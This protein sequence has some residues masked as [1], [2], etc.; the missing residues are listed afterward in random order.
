ML[1]FLRTAYPDASVDVAESSAGGVTIDIRFED[2][3]LVV[4]YSPRLGFGASLV[5]SDDQAFTGHD[6]AF[7]DS[8]EVIGYLTRA[9][10]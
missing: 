3:F 8:A 5:Q 4:Q 2:L 9:M 1:Q 7:A 6:H 10:R